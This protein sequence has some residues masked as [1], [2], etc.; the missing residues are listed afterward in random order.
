M[1]VK[2]TDGHLKGTETHIGR[3]VEVR[4]DQYIGHECYED[5][6]FVIEDDGHLTKVVFGAYHEGGAGGCAGSATVDATPEALALKQGFDDLCAELQRGLDE[7]REQT[8]VRKGKTVIVFKGRKV[9]V[10]TTGECFWLGST[11]YGERVGIRDAK[12][13]VHWTA[14]DNVR[15][16]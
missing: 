15:V 4:R 8:V 12:G 11:M 7:K 10:G 14:K 3:V 5:Q 1:S 16:A 2:W 6:A 9:P 13:T